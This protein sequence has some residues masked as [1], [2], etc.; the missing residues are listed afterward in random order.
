MIAIKC[1]PNNRMATQVWEIL[2]LSLHVYRIVHWRIQ[3]GGSK[4]IHSQLNSIAWTFPGKWR[5]RHLGVG[6]PTPL[7]NPGT[8][9]EISH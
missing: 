6:A 2:D 7:R 1:W 4:D 8:A 9:T 3:G 5:W